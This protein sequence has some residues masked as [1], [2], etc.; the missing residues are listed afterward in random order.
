VAR[1]PMLQCFHPLRAADVA[2]FSGR[3]ARGSAAR[4]SRRSG[5]RS[6]SYV[7]IARGCVPH[8]AALVVDCAHRS[9][10]AIAVVCPL[11]VMLSASSRSA[12]SKGWLLALLAL[13][14]SSS[15]TVPGVDPGGNG[16]PDASHDVAS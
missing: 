6:P 7:R 14:Y 8:G 5:G 3:A 1:R 2:V 15:E 12:R 11:G 16:A 13:A 4:G 9:N 10:R